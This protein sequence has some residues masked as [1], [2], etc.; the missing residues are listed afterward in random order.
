MAIF[1][2]HGGQTLE[3][4]LTSNF[5]F[6]DD[7]DIF[8]FVEALLEIQ[9]SMEVGDQLSENNNNHDSKSKSKLNGS[10]SNNNNSSS[11]NNATSEIVHNTCGNFF[12]GYFKP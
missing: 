8:S 2:L 1:Q 9:E 3:E 7:E 6:K 5:G 4:R 10:N 11:V 12:R